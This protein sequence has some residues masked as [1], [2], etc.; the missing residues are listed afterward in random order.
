MMKLKYL[1]A[2]WQVRIGEAILLRKLMHK[3][4]SQTHVFAD[5]VKDKCMM[6]DDGQY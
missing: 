3:Q 4:K 2:T 1:T 5:P 6:N